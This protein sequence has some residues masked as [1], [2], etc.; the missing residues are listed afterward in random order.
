MLCAPPRAVLFS[1]WVRCGGVRTNKRGGVLPSLL[2]DEGEVNRSAVA[3]TRSASCSSACCSLDAL[4]TSMPAS[5]RLA[6]RARLRLPGVGLR[7]LVLALF[8][9]GV[10][11]AAME[12]DSRSEEGDWTEGY[13]RD[14]GCSQFFLARSTLARR[15]PGDGVDTNSCCCTT[16]GSDVVAAVAGFAAGRRVGSVSHTDYTAMP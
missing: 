5:F 4:D 8:R 9:G 14:G 3:T 10:L 6:I 12:E 7:G 15:R 11:L 2:V 1:W 16:D 13:R